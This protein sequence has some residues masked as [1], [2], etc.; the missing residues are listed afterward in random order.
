MADIATTNPIIQS[1]P[2]RS[3]G[4][5]FF[6]ILMLISIIIVIILATNTDIFK[7]IVNRLFPKRTI[8]FEQSI[9]KKTAGLSNSIK[10]KKPAR[11]IASDGNVKALYIDR[12]KIYDVNNEEVFSQ[13]NIN[14][15]TD[16]IEIPFI[17]PINVRKIEIFPCNKDSIKACLTC[18]LDKCGI[19]TKID[20]NSVDYESPIYSKYNSCVVQNCENDCSKCLND[21]VGVEVILTGLSNN[22]QKIDMLNYI[23]SKGDFVHELLV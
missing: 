1:Q 7:P 20:L 15:T 5:F 21:I 23:I 18:S 3:L 22:N 6:N 8:D 14:I 13:N 17:N 2:K 11:F 4:D 9:V 12:I 10:I 16:S 19:E